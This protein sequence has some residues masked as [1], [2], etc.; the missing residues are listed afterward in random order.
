MI[1][2]LMYAFAAMA[3]IVVLGLLHKHAD[4][5]DCRPEQVNLLL[6]GWSALLGL[7]SLAGAGESPAVPLK[8]WEVALPCG[9]FAA[10][11]VLMFQIGVRQGLIATS[12]LVINLSAAIPVAV[13]VAWY[14]ERVSSRQAMAL[15]AMIAALILLWLDRRTAAS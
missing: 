12:W 1:P 6:F 15:A 11:A 9:I 13:S 5:R 10:A 2:P 3:M 7:V 4:R 14:G 8:V